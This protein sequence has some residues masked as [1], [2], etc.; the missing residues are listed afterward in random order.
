M[1]ATRCSKRLPDPR[2]PGC[3]GLWTASD[4]VRLHT[5]GS[6]LAPTDAVTGKIGGQW[7]LGQSTVEKG[8]YVSPHALRME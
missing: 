2:L 6:E 5:W 7:G 4:D 3:A 8:S 1:N